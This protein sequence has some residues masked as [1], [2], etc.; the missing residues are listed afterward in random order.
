MGKENCSR[1]QVPGSKI[2][3]AGIIPQ[4]G[5]KISFLG[6]IA[7]SI[8]EWQHCLE[9]LE[10]EPLGLDGYVEVLFGEKEEA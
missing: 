9:T 7:M 2:N 1:E 4:R 6:K 8:G 5:H 10:R 3:C